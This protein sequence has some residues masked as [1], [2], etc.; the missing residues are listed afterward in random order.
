MWRSVSIVCEPG[1][2]DMVSSCIFESGF[3]GLEEH[4]SNGKT[5]YRAF[6]RASPEVPDPVESLSGFFTAAARRTGTKP[7]EIRSIDGVAEEDWET[8]WRRGLTAVEIGSRLVIKPSWVE[9][10]NPGKRHVV[11]INPKMAFGTGGHETTR[12]CLEIL[13]SMDLRELSVLD[14]GCGSGILSIAAVKLGARCA[15][16][17]DNDPYALANAIE[18]VKANRVHEMVTVYRA[19]LATVM[20]GRFDLVF[21]NMISG[22]LL[23]NLGRFRGFLTPGGLAVF[24]GL[25]REEEAEFLKNLARTGFHVTDVRSLGEWIAVMCERR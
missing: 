16:G 8:S 11:T 6:Y 10:P 4:T 13:E 7:A 15:I 21:A 5:E 25:L 2:E 19:E 9:Y 22:A 24:S 20:P 3:S 1:F 12:L 23:P 14:A 18:N 17:F